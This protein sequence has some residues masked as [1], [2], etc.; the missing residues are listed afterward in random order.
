MTSLIESSTEVT[1]RLP[2]ESFNESLTVSE[3]FMREK[4]WPRETVATQT[5][6]D[7]YIR[8][9]DDGLL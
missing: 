9:D 5:G 6:N 7:V 2:T 8:C 4:I 1:F 3:L